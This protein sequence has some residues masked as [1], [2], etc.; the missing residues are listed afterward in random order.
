MGSSSTRSFMRAFD[1]VFPAGLQLVMGLLIAALPPSVHGAD[2]APSEAAKIEYLI[3]G[4]S[5]LQQA[6]FIRNGRA[7]D[8]KS[9]ASHLR[10][11]LKA[12]GPRVQSAEDFIVLC[13]TGSSITGKPYRIRFSD[14]RVV[15]AQQYFRR[16]LADYPVRT[17]PGESDG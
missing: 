16:R 2:L 11:K 17:E 4:I 8:A 14:G 10:R 1:N 15:D 5:E 6:Q 9:A 12:A 7:H 13:A 3:V